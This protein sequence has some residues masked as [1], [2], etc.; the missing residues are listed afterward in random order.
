MKKTNCSRRA[1]TLIELLVVIAIIAIL[2]AL[3]L[4]AVQQ[5]R[6]AAR[7]SSCK[8]NLKQIGLALHN[9]HDIH[10]VFPA[11]S[12]ENEFWGGD[13]TRFSSFSW[14]TM[15]LPQL[16][17]APLFDILSPGNPD[18]LWRT[19]AADDDR[20]EAMEKG[21]SAF[22]CPS[23]HGPQVNDERS[24][25]D[26]TG[27]SNGKPLATSNY[28][29]VNHTSNI[30]RTSANGLFVSAS[31]AESNKVRRRR[32]RDITDGT[33]NTLA[34]G[35]R[36]YELNGYKTRA[37]VVFGHNGNDGASNNGFAGVLGSG[38]A[39]I[40]TASTAGERGFSSLHTG[41]AQF[42]LADGS[43]RFISENIDHRVQGAVD[44]TFE[45]LIAVQDGK[46]VGEF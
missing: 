15:L 45:Y 6:E 27:S 5:A 36:A 26:G 37:A 22:R 34:V 32:M 13:D 25:N 19:V 40:N 29:G 17:Q 3:L 44:S 38:Y 16:E 21:Y 33:S 12:Y 39:T 10:R 35:E 41:G 30:N 4:P 18:P 46:V 11:A 28:V 43:V 2:V 7:R 31:N 23:D 9:Y 1:F 20:L 8:N 42:V 14:G 24:I